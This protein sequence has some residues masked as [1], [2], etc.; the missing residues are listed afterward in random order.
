MKAVWS[1]NPSGTNNEIDFSYVL[2]EHILKA[3]SVD[4]S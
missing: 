2:C 4:G 1:Q 3:I